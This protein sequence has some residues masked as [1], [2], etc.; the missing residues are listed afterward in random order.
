MS[1]ANLKQMVDAGVLDAVSQIL[2]VT[3]KDMEQW[4]S[5]GC[6]QILDARH[7]VTGLFGNLCLSDETIELVRGHPSCLRALRSAVSDREVRLSGQHQR[8]LL[9]LLAKFEHAGGAA[10]TRTLQASSST[11]AAAAAAADSCQAPTSVGLTVPA[12]TS[13]ATGHVMLSYCWD[14]QDVIR[15]IREGLRRRNVTVWVDYEDMSG[16][17]VDAMAQAIDDASV[18][19]YGVSDTYKKSANCRLEASYAH[20]CCVPMLPLM[21][22]DGYK[23]RGWLGMFMGTGLWHGFF[24]ATLE[25]DTAFEKQMDALC[26]AISTKQAEQ[27]AT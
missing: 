6:F 21:L 22:E 10:V 13:S 3:L 4:P 14:N 8:L 20:Q 17:V 19:L 15:R 26:N 11:A 9:G 25:S 18:M 24:G 12:P 16:S 27:T 1:D 23:P 7:A 5:W 2:T